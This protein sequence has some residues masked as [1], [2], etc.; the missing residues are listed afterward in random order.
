MSLVTEK[1]I[2]QRQQCR[3]FLEYHRG[4]KIEHGGNSY[5][6]RLIDEHK[7]LMPSQKPP[8]TDPS[9]PE[10]GKCLWLTSK[11][12]PPESH[13]QRYS[14][15]S[16]RHFNKRKIQISIDAPL[17]VLLTLA[18]LLRDGIIVRSC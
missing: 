9:M 15:R 12:T 18:F 14:A 13:V 8:A 6:V 4:L 1:W 10:V 5:L 16:R 7:T 3:M 17:T 2:L 11:A